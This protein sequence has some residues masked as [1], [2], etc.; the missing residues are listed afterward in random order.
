[1]IATLFLI[2]VL[3]NMC[4]GNND[5]ASRQPSERMLTYTLFSS[6]DPLCAFSAVY[7]PRVLNNYSTVANSPLPRPPLDAVAAACE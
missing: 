1:M 3:R 6:N 4:L 5:A 2:W 7:S